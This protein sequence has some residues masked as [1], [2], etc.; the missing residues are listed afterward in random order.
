MLQVCI[1]PSVCQAQTCL[2]QSTCNLYL[3]DSDLRAVFSALFRQY[4]IRQTEP[5]IS[6]LVVI[7]SLNQ[8]IGY[9]NIQ[10][11]RFISLLVFCPY[12]VL[13]QL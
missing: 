10:I 12:Y 1:H 6:R 5:E 3:F 4:F 2:E 9:W 13:R 8:T 7:I 11:L